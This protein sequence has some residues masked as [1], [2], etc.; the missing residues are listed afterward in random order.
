MSKLTMAAAGAVGY[1]LGARAGRERYE[2]LSEKA[3]SLWNNPKVQKGKRRAQDKA[4]EVA[5]DDSSTEFGD[6]AFGEA[7]DQQQE[8]SGQFN[9]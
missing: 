4:Q 1:V 5:S 2:Q 6:S 7:G 9:V 8:N 3:E